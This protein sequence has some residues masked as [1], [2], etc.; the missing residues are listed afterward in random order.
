MGA[1]TSRRLCT[2]LRDSTEG[3][4]V[5]LPG[6]HR[7]AYS[8]RHRVHIVW[9]V[10]VAEQP[11]NAE[12]IADVNADTT[13]DVNADTTADTTAEVN[14]PRRPSTGPPDNRAHPDVGVRRSDR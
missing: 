7:G 10:T 6:D 8:G 14:V 4:Y 13:A 12:S 3:A 2:R 5:Q 9:W 1:F 11:G